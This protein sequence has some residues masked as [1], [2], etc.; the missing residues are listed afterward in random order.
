MLV[1]YCIV[2]YPR[3]REYA[4]RRDLGGR[5][6]LVLVPV[7]IIEEGTATTPPS[8]MYTGNHWLVGCVVGAV[9]IFGGVAMNG[10]YVNPRRTDGFWDGM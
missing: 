6:V 1:R 4:A 10:M 8:L 3:W 9:A 5:M 2:Q 7:Q